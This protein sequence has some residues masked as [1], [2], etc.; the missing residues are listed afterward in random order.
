MQRGRDT[1]SLARVIGDVLDPFTKSISPRVFYNTREV[2]N[3]CDLRPSHVNNQPRV[4]VGGDDLR[5]FY[6]LV[7]LI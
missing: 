4:E 5:T 3:G 6:T 2:K 7:C 1:L